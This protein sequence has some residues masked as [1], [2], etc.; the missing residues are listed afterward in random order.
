VASSGTA[1]RV[2]QRADCMWK[3]RGL[4]TEELDEARMMVDGGGRCSAVGGG[5][6]PCMAPL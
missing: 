6:V 2:A 3:A 4:L 1:D 5:E